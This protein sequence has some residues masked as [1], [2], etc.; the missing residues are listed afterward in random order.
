MGVNYLTELNRSRYPLALY[1]EALAEGASPWKNGGFSFFPGLPSGVVVRSCRKPEYK[2]L[3]ALRVLTPPG[4][5]LD[6]TLLE[7]LAFC[8]GQFGIDL[9]QFTTGGTVQL[10]LEREQV[11]R[12]SAYLKDHGLGL[13]SSGDGLR[14]V[15]A[16][17]GPRL[18]DQAVID[19][20]ELAWFLGQYFAED[21]Q[22]PSF[23]N[24]VKLGV[25]G[26]PVDCLRAAQ[27]KDIALVGVQDP[28]RG[29]GLKIYLGG[30]CGSRGSNG[31][32]PGCLIEPF[33]ALQD[34]YQ[35]VAKFVGEVLETWNE[36]GR[37]KERLGN[38]IKRRGVKWFTEQLFS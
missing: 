26:C 2:E 10:F 38:L 25:S 6:A 18:C 33:F 22:Y 34:G 29:T 1:R 17:P 5:W 30:K 27:Q 28:C 13:G 24:K 9:L 15:T 8:A 16:C 14:A 21:Q 31:A 11:P 35:P 32:L 36:H 23:I 20:P 7:S 4:G 3:I 12:A 37:R 19:A